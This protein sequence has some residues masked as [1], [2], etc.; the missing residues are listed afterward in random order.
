MI[1]YK[2]S[3]DKDKE[4][5]TVL[6][7]RVNA[8]FQENQINQ[9][10]DARMVTKST[11]VLLWYIIPYIIILSAGITSIPILLSLWIIMGVAKTIIGTTIM[12]D[13]IHYSYSKKKSINALM[14]VSGALIGVDRLIW[15]IQHNVLHHTYPNVEDADE[16]ILPRIM[17]RFSQHQPRKWFHRFQHIYAPIFYCVPLLEWITT[18]DFILAFEY[19]KRKLIAPDIFW[20]E[21][22]GI[23]LRKVA[24]WAVFLVPPFL[25]VDIPAM[26]MLAMII[27]SHCIAGNLIAMIF[28]TAHVIPT[29]YFLKEETENIDQSFVRHQLN[30]TSNYGM[31]DKVLTWFLG[32][33]NFQ[34]EHHL[35][36]NI[37]H[38]HY[39]KISKI[40]Q[41]T[42]KEF[43]L[44]YHYEKSF[45]S[46][47]ASH[48]RHLKDLGKPGYIPQVELGY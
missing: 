14:S 36:P 34:V 3:T 27:F 33:L 9:N 47:V 20:K 29:N 43:D 37:C 13:S 17:F 21:F 1:K 41:T 38:V 45:S 15:K 30:T 12:H 48:Y 8:Y 44:P 2:F 35:F 10:A 42:T 39:P 25:L 6:R 28:Q 26:T 5:T 32:G 18:K 11:V 24:Y 46:A 23:V 16:D 19:K 31:D 4:F 7:Q 22:A 40:V